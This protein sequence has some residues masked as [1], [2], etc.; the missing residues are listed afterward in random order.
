MRGRALRAGSASAV[1]AVDDI[2]ITLCQFGVIGKHAAC[3][4]LMERTACISDESI[5][6]PLFMACGLWKSFVMT[7]RG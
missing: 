1:Q 6:L 4:A 3:L 5:K 7:E 2:G